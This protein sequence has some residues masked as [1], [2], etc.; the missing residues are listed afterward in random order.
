MNAS[1][2]IRLIPEKFFEGLALETKVDHRVKKLSGEVIFKLV[3][4]SLLNAEKLSL[5]VRESFLTL[6]TFRSFAQAGEVESKYN[7]IHDRICTIDAACFE[8]L[9]AQVFTICNKQRR[10]EIALA[11]AD[12]T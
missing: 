1:E 10:E 11:K 7:S 8:K 2:L 5:R 4:F 6:A 3:L 12:S 9:F